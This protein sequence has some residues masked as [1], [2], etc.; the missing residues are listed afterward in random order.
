MSENISFCYFLS[1]LKYKQ[2]LN[3]SD[4]K[5]SKN[6]FSDFKRHMLYPVNN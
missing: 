5:N 3:S 1:V 2:I 6:T 4:S